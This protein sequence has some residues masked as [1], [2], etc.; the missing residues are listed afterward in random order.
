MKVF[1]DSVRLELLI[2]LNAKVVKKALLNGFKSSCQFFSKLFYSSVLERPVVKYSFITLYIIMKHFV[3]LSFW[4][5]LYCSSTV[6]F[7]YEFFQL[8]DLETLTACSL[9][10]LASLWST[11]LDKSKWILFLVL[12]WRRTRLGM[13]LQ[14]CDVCDQKYFN[15]RKK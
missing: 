5:N 1:K 12:N 6:Y 15:C 7:C 9:F 8:D 3:F 13:A 4:K 2:N 14:I 10:Q 11:S